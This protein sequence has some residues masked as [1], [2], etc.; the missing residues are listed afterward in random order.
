M[1]VN[2]MGVKFTKHGKVGYKNVIHIL[3]FSFKLDNF[4]KEIAINK[5]T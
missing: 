3:L 5:R 2:R 4:S 1:I